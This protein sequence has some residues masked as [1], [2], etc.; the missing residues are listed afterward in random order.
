[1]LVGD[2]RVFSIGRLNERLGEVAAAMLEGNRDQLKVVV[3]VGRVEALPAWQL[4]TAAS[5]RSPEVQQEPLAAQ[6]TQI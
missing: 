3:A 4:F 1:M 2:D 5:P 6:L